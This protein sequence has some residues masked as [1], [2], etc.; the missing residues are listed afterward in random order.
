MHANVTLRE[1]CQNMK[2]FLVHIF[3]AFEFNTEK[4]GPEQTPY[5]K[6]FHSVSST[7]LFEP[8]LFLSGTISVI[9]NSPC[10]Y[11]FKLNNGNTRAM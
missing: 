3:P 4:H 5:L 9:I 1:D 8:P 7:P 2:F 11:L 6:N 10:T